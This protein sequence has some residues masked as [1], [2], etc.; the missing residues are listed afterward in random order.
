MGTYRQ[1]HNFAAREERVEEVARAPLPDVAAMV[2]E[3][4]AAPAYDEHFQELVDSGG[5]AQGRAE[6]YVETASLGLVSPTM[7]VSSFASF[8]IDTDF[9]IGP[10]AMAI[11]TGTSAARLC[12]GFMQIAARPGG[13][14]SLIA[15]AFL[16]PRLAAALESDEPRVF[17]PVTAEYLGLAAPQVR[18][19]RL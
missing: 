5:G 15:T 14:G 13:D 6:R 9:G 12:A 7:T 11:P 3:A 8:R 1:C 17:R 18:H 10:A 2:R 16:W 19:S 4:I